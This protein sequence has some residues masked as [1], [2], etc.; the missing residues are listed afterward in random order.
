[1]VLEVDPKDYKAWYGLGQL[2][3]ILKMHHYAVYYY[4]MAHKLR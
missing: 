3:E 4:D 1:M 2:Y